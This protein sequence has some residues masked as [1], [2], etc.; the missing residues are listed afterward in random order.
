MKTGVSRILNGHMYFNGMVIKIR[1][2]L[3]KEVQNGAYLRDE[4]QWCDYYHNLFDMDQT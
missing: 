2:D 3:L 1:L 4:Y